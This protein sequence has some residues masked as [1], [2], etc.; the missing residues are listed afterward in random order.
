ML[1]MPRLIRA[2]K[3]VRLYLLLVQK[4]S[5]KTGANRHIGGQEELDQ[6]AEINGHR[7]DG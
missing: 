5:V 6:V 3:R 2:W 1:D 7:G 4:G